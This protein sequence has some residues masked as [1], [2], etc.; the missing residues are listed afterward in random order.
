M[1]ILT[2]YKTSLAGVA[3][4]LSA[5]GVLAAG[6]SKGALD[7]TTLATAIGLFMTGLQGLF[8]KDGT[9]HSTEAQVQTATVQAQ[10]AAKP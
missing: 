7:N 8:A 4:I 3:S 9:T 1:S 10:I 6:F 5:L 2:N